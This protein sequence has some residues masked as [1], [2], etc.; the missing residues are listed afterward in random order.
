ME[1]L[2]KNFPL[3]YI[4]LARKKLK[5]NRDSSGLHQFAPLPGMNG[6][7]GLQIVTDAMS[8]NSLDFSRYLALAGRK[9]NMQI[10]QNKK[11]FS[12]MDELFREGTFLLSCLPFKMNTGMKF[13]EKEMNTLCI[14]TP[15]IMASNSEGT[16]R[17]YFPHNFTD[18]EKAERLILI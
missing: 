4:T 1:R 16:F 11:D 18:S 17:I 15:S 6:S 8:G 9:E 12:I 7:A 5:H 10:N 2:Y 14:D 3:K 13:P